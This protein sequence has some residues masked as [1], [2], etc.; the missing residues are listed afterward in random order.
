MRTIPINNTAVDLA[1]QKVP[2]LS[3]FTFVAVNFTGGA[4]IVQ[5]SDTGTGSWTAVKSSNSVAGTVRAAGADEITV[6]KQFVRV[7]TAA[8]I[9]LLGN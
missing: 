9:T 4:L 1:A 7:S 5:E 8:N 3:G 2:F 6:R